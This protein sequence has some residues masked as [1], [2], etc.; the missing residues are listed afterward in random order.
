[1]VLGSTTN[2]LNPDM[3]MPEKMSLSVTY[4]RANSFGGGRLTSFSRG[5]GYLEWFVEKVPNM[6]GV[7]KLYP[8]AV[9]REL[10]V[11][12]NE[13]VGRKSPSWAN[14]CPKTNP[15]TRELPSIK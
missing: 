15:L 11:N 13:L 3:P 8:K 6:R 2:G 12:L 9:V 7:T 1:M 5:Q 14:L 10:G 4:A